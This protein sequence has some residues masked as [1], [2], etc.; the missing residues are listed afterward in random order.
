M[1]GAKRPEGERREEILA[2]AYR[3]AVREQLG[4]LSM[5]AVAHEAGVSK[6]LVFF[7]FSDKETLLRELL[8]WLLEDAP[9]VEVPADLDPA[10]PGRRLVQVVEHQV[11][12]LPARQGRV[13]LFLDFWVMGTGVPELRARIRTAFDRYRAEFLPYTRAVAAAMPDRFDGDDPDG[14][15]AVLVSFIQG[16][17]LQMNAAPETFDVARYVRALRDLVAVG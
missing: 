13:Q 11:A 3:V 7:H 4:G 8:D 9:R 12:L 5:R 10:H 17:A 16:C 1:P 15:A 2:A 14:L 6:G